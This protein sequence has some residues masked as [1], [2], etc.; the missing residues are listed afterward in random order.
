MRCQCSAVPSQP[1]RYIAVGL[2]T[3]GPIA[4]ERMVKDGDG[5]GLFRGHRNS[6]Q[7]H[8]TVNRVGNFT[9]KL[10]NLDL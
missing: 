2:A 6:I 4:N 5:H 1:L 7:L 8:E 9:E 3:N 10:P